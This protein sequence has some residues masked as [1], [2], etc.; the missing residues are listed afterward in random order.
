MQL[1]LKYLLTTS[2]LSI[3]CASTLF[4]TESQDKFSRQFLFKK[5]TVLPSAN[6]ET[7][8]IRVTFKPGYKTPVHTHEGPG[9]RYVIKGK[10]RVEDNGENHVYEAGEVFWESGAAMTVE[11]IGTDNAEMVIFQI[12]TAK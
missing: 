8:V 5:Q 1:N 6:V 4:A 9:P 7:Q 12:I 11:N 10:L 2:L 3:V